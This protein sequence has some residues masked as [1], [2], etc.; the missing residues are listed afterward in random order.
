MYIWAITREFIFMPRLVFIFFFVFF[1]KFAINQPVKIVI[2]HPTEKNIDNLLWLLQNKIIPINEYELIGFYHTDETYDYSQ[3]EQRPGVR[4]IACQGEI[5]DSVVFQK[6]ACS[7]D[8]QKVFEMADA[9]LFH[10]GPDIPPVIY[11]EKTHV[12]TEITDPARHCFEISFLFHLVGNIKNTTQQALLTNKSK[13]P[14]WCFCLGMQSL[15]VATGGTLWQ[16]IPSQLYGLNFMEDIIAFNQENV[17]KNYRTCVSPLLYPG[18]YQKHPVQVD[19][20]NFPV[21]FAGFT[22]KFLPDVFSWHHQAVKELGQNLQILAFSPDEKV[23]EIVQHKVFNNVMGFQFHPE[24]AD[25]YKNNLP[26]S[27]GSRTTDEF[28][29]NQASMDFHTGL[30][31]HFGKILVIPKN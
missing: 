7:P 9:I 3:V 23:V 27:A 2:M 29:L 12:T 8:F 28:L 25:I 22:A 24:N 1:A 14:V 18:V 31:N 4:F 30:W 11:G 19:F 17:H 20:Q 16:D 10:G 5:S 15:N 6:N 13:M 21:K 26:F